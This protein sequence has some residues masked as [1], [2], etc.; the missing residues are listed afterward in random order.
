MH[1]SQIAPMSGKVSWYRKW[2]LAHSLSDISKHFYLEYKE[3]RC[4]SQIRYFP[5]YFEE[6]ALW[7]VCSKLQQKDGSFI[8]K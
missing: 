1:N 7:G 8:S 3:E 5:S 6:C 4:S 2:L